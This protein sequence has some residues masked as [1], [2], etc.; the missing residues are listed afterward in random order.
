MRHGS[1][2]QPQGIK[3]CAFFMSR[4]LSHLFKKHET[5][6]SPTATRDYILMS[7]TFS[8]FT[9]KEGGEGVEIDRYIYR[10]KGYGRFYKKSMRHFTLLIL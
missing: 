3:Q 7:H 1:V 4:L 5:W 2:L 6:F 10:Y 8:L 9:K